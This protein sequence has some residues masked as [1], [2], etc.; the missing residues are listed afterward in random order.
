MSVL[1]CSPRRCWFEVKV[2]TPREKYGA[3][4][5]SLP[6]RL[7]APVRSPPRPGSAL[8][9]VRYTA[10]LMDSVPEAR[11]LRPEEMVDQ[12]PLLPLTRQPHRR[13]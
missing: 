2:C 8:R 3:A 4:Y 10:E 12:D 1:C 11:V 6:S 9:D 5:H 13:R 7:P